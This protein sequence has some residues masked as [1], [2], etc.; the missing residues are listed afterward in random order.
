MEDGVM[1]EATDKLEDNEIAFK[2]K[3]ITLKKCLSLF[4]SCD[5]CYY[6]SPMELS[7]YNLSFFSSLFKL[8]TIDV[9][10]VD[11]DVLISNLMF[12]YQLS[13]ICKIKP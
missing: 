1:V 12:N 3:K 13:Y 4:K 9:F 2:L 10:F 5:L 7:C 6:F 8:P 11:R